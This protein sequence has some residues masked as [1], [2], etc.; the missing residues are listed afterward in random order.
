M[1]EMDEMS[2]MMSSDI[3]CNVEFIG[4]IVKIDTYPTL[5]S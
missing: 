3:V 4:M 1:D 2:M 5:C